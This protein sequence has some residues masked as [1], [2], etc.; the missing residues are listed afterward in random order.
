[1]HEF[2]LILPFMLLFWCDATLYSQHTVTHGTLWLTGPSTLLGLNTPHWCMSKGKVACWHNSPDVILCGWLGSKHQLTKLTN[3]WHK[4]WT[5]LQKV[6]TYGQSMRL[7]R[8]SNHF[9]LV[10]K[11]PIIFRIPFVS[12]NIFRVSKQNVKGW[13]G[14]FEIHSKC[15]RSFQ[16]HPVAAE[17]S[18]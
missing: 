7:L 4:Q 1:M 12:Y 14:S 16:S 10:T 18:W 8:T 6:D 2:N 13:T 9:F 11:Y 17:M 3:C 15:V 5:I